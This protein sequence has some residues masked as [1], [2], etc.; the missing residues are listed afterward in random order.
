[1]KIKQHLS[2]TALR[3]KM[4]EVFN[5]IPDQRQQNKVS[6]SLHD[7]LMGG[8]A[9]MHFQDNSLL[10]FQKRMQEAQRK[11]N[12]N[13]FFEVNNIP[14][15]TQMRDIIDNVSSNYFKPIFFR[16]LHAITTWKTIRTISNIF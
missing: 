11:N 9:C 10:Q 6:V 2:F 14:S 5:S 8:F 1:M 15:D 3:K 12:L 7:A 13:T 4:S 16:F